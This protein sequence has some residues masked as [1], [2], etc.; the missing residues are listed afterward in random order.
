MSKLAKFV[1]A[2][3]SQTEKFK[4]VELVA[5]TK[6]DYSIYNGNSFAGNFNPYRMECWGGVSNELCAV[7]QDLA[8]QYQQ[9][10]IS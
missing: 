5:S 6:G 9:A 2:K 10:I 4:N 7:L 1:N 8:S 3:L